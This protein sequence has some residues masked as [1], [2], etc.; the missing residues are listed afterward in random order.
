MSRK[1]KINVYSQTKGKRT[2]VGTLWREAGKYIFEYDRSYQRLK[3]AV[4]LGPEFKLWKKRF[5]SKKLF[6]SIVDRIPSKE[7]PAYADYCAQ[8][9]I[10]KDEADPFVL[11]TTIGRR[12]PSTFVFEAG[13]DEDYSALDVKWFRKH[14]KLNQREFAA[15]FGITQ[16][17]LVKLETGRTEYPLILSYI[18]LC[19][20]VPKALSWLLQKRGQYLHDEKR[21]FIANLISKKLENRDS[22]SH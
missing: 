18:Q 12:G 8:W 3:N 19:K 9:G 21:V 7:N 16:A 20:K 13:N 4:A 17:T 6:P 10:N 2:F 22:Q 11:L 15:L 5:S 14:L 1:N